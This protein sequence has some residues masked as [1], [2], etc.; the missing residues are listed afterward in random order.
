MRIGLRMAFVLSVALAIALPASAQESKPAPAAG[1]KSADFDKLFAQ[2]KALLEQLRQLRE[3]YRSADSTRKQA[4]SKQYGELVAQGEAMEPQVIESALAAFDE[5]PRANQE[6]TD[7]LLGLTSMN[8]S[9]DN[10]EEALRLG[11]KL[12]EKGVEPKGLHG[13]AGTAALA[14]GE[15]DLAEKWLKK[16]DED[17][18]LTDEGRQRMA[19]IEYYRE[20]W[21]KEQEIRKAEAAANDLPRVLLK[22]N[23]GD[24]V[25]ELFE[26]EAPNT[27]A[28]FISLVESGFYNGLTFH[29]VLPAFMAQGGCPDGTGGGGPGYHIACECYEPNHRLHFR[30]TLS[31][32]HAGRDTGGS[33]FFLTFLPTRHLDGRHTAFGRVVEGMEVLGEIQRR[34]P[35]DPNSPDPDKIVEAKVLRKRNH[36]YVPK[37]VGR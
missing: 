29:R 4:I 11:K 36:P 13:L 27:V 10:Y 35:E 2:W 24:I 22:T 21:P 16:A 23:K 18:T 31:M 6:L 3:E 37:K 32:A 26:N 19:N 17:G 30:G 8:V 12:I 28:N 34:D 20:A 14:V 9:Q 15:L 33:Q 7:F 1:S 5:A 25:V